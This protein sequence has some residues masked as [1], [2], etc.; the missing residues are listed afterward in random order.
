MPHFSDETNDNTKPTAR[1]EFSAAESISMGWGD[2]PCTFLV[3]L[4]LTQ[5]AKQYR[6]AQRSKGRRSVSAGGALLVKV[7]P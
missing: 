2:Q 3:S 7:S 1:V 4:D 5:I 6:A